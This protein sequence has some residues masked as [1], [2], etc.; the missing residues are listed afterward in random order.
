[1]QAASSACQ[2]NTKTLLNPFPEKPPYPLAHGFIKERYNCGAALL[3]TAAFP[4]HVH[5][6]PGTLVSSK[7]TQCSSSH[8]PLIIFLLWKDYRWCLGNISCL[9][10]SPP[11]EPVSHFRQQPRIRTLSADVSSHSSGKFAKGWKYFVSQIHITL[12]C[13]FISTLVIALWRSKTYIFTSILNVEI[14]NF[15]FLPLVF[16]RAAGL[17]VTITVLATWLLRAAW[18]LESFHRNW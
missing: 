16:A 14:D 9:L 11:I 5:S 12:P 18:L 6:D 10:S 7:N 8:F 3:G 1:M 15:L 17:A 2:T 4:D 13:L